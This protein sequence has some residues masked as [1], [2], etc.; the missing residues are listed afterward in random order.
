MLCSRTARE[1][2][3]IGGQAVASLHRD[4]TARAAI[5]AGATDGGTDRDARGAAGMGHRRNGQRKGVGIAARAATR[6]P[7]SWR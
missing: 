4:G 1:P 7:G 5:T 3:P 2:I 6:R